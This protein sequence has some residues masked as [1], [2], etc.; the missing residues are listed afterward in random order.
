MASVALGNRVR[1]IVGRYLFVMFDWFAQS[2]YGFY[3]F[4]R[5]IFGEVS[6]FSETSFFDHGDSPSDARRMPRRT[7]KPWGTSEVSYYLEFYWVP[8]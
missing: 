8:A 1:A 2:E 7:P 3:V 4:P 5:R 6:F